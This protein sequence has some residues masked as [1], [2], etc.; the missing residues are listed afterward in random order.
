[1]GTLNRWEEKYRFNGLKVRG[2]CQ[3]E[4]VFYALYYWVVIVVP[5]EQNR[6]ERKGGECV[7]IYRFY[8]GHGSFR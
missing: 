4:G 3:D 7:E 6:N 5:D 1:M 8:Q 2:R